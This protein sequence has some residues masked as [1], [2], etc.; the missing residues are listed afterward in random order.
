MNRKFIIPLVLF[1]ICLALAATAERPYWPTQNSIPLETNFGFKDVAT[2]TINIT[3]STLVE[4][5]DYLPA[6]TI[7]FELRAK[8]NAFVV[9]HSD[10]IATGT[11]RVGRIVLE[12]TTYSWNGLGGTFNGVIVADVTSA[13]VVIDAA[14]GDYEE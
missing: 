3:D 11:N 2:P 7:G 9:G 10:D 4:L 13:T 5:D 14:W 12:G 1:F 8:N 6:G